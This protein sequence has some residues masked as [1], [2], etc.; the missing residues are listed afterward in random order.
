MSLAVRVVTPDDSLPRSLW[1]V[2]QLFVGGLTF[3]AMHVYAFA[4]AGAKANRLSPFD[5]VVHPLDVWRPT[6]QELPASA[7]RVWAGLWG[8]TAAVCAVTIIGGIRYSV[9]TDDWGFKQRPKQN[10]MK[11]IKEQ[12]LANMKDAEEGADNLNDAI[13]DFAGDDEAKKKK[14]EKR[15][16]EMLSADCVVVGYNVDKET[17]QVTELVLASLVDDK[18]QYVGTISGNIPPEIEEQLQQK[19]P[20]LEQEQPFLKCPVAAKWVKPTVTCRAAFKS[21]SENKRMQQPVFKE[22][23]ADADAK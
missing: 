15:E 3:I 7:R 9:L 19:L 2:T 11:S 20:G 6:F 12:M 16:I 10:L 13:K 8:L 1:S 18:L 14:E 5:I 22:L 17:G 23:L 21:W 4:K